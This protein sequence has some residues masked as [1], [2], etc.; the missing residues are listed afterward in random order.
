V[1]A[2]NFFGKN[3]SGKCLQGVKIWINQCNGPSK[4]RLGPQNEKE[5]VSSDYKSCRKTSRRSERMTN[6]SATSWKAKKKMAFAG[7]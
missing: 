1:I 2:R 6:T 5:K 3:I 4:R 7:L